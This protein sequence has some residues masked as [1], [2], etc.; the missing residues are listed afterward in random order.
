[1]SCMMSDAGGHY[2]P[3]KSDDL[4][5]DVCGQVII[6][7]IIISYIIINVSSFLIPLLIYVFA[8][9]DYHIDVLG[10]APICPCRLNFPLMILG[11]FVFFFWQI[12]YFKRQIGWHL[13]AFKSLILKGRQCNLS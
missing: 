6:I 4:C 13:C 7:I 1:M 11:V 10:V 2:C 12:K 8:I 3:K 5:G 9:L